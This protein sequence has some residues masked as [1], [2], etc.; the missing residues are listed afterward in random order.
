MSQTKLFAVFL[1]VQSFQTVMQ[2]YLHLVPIKRR[3]IL[4]DQPDQL[5]ISH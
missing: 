4:L 1:G 2:H 5:Y 3:P